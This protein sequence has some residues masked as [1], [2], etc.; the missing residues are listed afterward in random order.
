VVVPQLSISW[1]RPAVAS[2]TK[3]SRLIAWMIALR[4]SCDAVALPLDSLNQN[5]KTPKTY[6][7]LANAGGACLTY[8]SGTAATS[9]PPERSRFSRV[10]W[11]LTTV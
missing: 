4:T 10:F 2:C 8:A 11:S 9:T 3:V 7:T 5:M 1:P 6:G